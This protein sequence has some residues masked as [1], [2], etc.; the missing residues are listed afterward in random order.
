MNIHVRPAGKQDATFLWS[1]RN[2]PDVYRHFRNP[3][4]VSWEEHVAWM[5]PRILGPHLDMLF[6]LEYE[7]VLVGQFRLDKA[8]NKS[9]EVSISLL[10]EYRGKGIARQ[11]LK[12]AIMYVREQGHAQEIIAEIHQDNIASQHLF[13]GAGFQ[14]FQT[15]DD[16]FQYRLLIQ[17]QDY[18]DSLP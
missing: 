5:M 4:P 2:R 10:Q 3:L 7:G 15:N 12:N 17:D 11:A 16:F 6:V 9:V 14:R 18:K 1:L 13:E 8:G